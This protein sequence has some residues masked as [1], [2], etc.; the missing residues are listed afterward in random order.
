ML[1]DAALAHDQLHCT[2][3]IQCH[4]HTHSV[5]ASYSALVCRQIRSFAN[6]FWGQIKCL[7]KPL[8]LV[9]VL[10]H[11]SDIFMVARPMNIRRCSRNSHYC[12]L[13]HALTGNSIYTSL[14]HFWDKLQEKHSTGHQQKPYLISTQIWNEVVSYMS[15]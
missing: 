3:H 5:C 2:M 12:P 6:K 9:T 8:I 11:I 14:I 10:W 13:S 15:I 7:P 1:A 4:T